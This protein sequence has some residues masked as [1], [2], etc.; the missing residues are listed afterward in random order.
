MSTPFP[1]LHYYYHEAT[2]IWV[3]MRRVDLE[4]DMDTLH[5]W[6]NEPHTIAQWK[7]NHPIDLLRQHFQKALENRYQSLFIISIHEKEIGYAEVYD[8][9]HDRLANFC[10][11]FPNDYGLHLLIGPPDAL[12]KGNSELILCA[13]CD[14]LFAVKKANRVLVEPHCD[15]KQFT[16]LE[17]K[18]GFSNNGYLSLPEKKAILYAAYSE[19]FYGRYPKKRMET[20]SCDV[21]R[22]PIIR[23]HFPRSPTDKMVEMWLNELD[24]LL[25]RIEH[26]VVISTFDSDYQFSVE[27]RRK[28]ALWFK[29]N[30][31]WLHLY[32]IGMV[33]VTND[34]EIIRK[35]KAPAMRK[36]MPFVC[37]PARSLH[38]AEHVANQLL[39]EFDN[40]KGK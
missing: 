30:K 33:R 18:L 2:K 6:L 5:A 17:R 11:I 25:K 21:T 38:E 9:T 23:M 34:P 36:G 32:C 20:L 14:Y 35:I 28:Q 16:I 39:L 31:T 7:L 22:W 26:C 1:G 27:A 19:N 40:E 3:K 12:G 8:A 29:R 10:D 15:V 37:I 24:L 4:K 13:L